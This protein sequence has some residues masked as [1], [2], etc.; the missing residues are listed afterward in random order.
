MKY[1][2]NC[3]ELSVRVAGR[4][5][6]QVLKKG[7]VLATEIVA[8]YSESNLRAMVH[9]GRLIVDGEELSNKKMPGASKK[10]GAKDE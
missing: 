4:N 2:V 6:A 8:L 1:R 3:E 5:A 9:D 10:K 7:S